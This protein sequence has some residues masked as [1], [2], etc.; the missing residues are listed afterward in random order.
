MNTLASVSEDGS[1]PLATTHG[2]TNFISI[3]QKAVET[4]KFG[5]NDQQTGKPLR[6]ITKCG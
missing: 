1:H 5:Q 4:F 2:C 6:F 3:Y